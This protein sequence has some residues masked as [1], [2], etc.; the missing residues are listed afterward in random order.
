MYNF[1]TSFC[2]HSRS[3]LFFFLVFKH[4]VVVYYFHFKSITCQNRFSTF[5]LYVPKTYF[6]C[7][8]NRLNEPIVSYC[9]KSKN[10]SLS[11][12]TNPSSVTYRK[13]VRGW[14]FGYDEFR[15]RNPG[16]HEI[17]IFFVYESKSKF[18]V[19]CRGGDWTLLTPLLRIWMYL[20]MFYVILKLDV[21]VLVR[22]SGK[23]EI[24]NFV[25]HSL[26]VYGKIRQKFERFD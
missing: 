9:G 2:I 18:F 26:N 21:F 22:W 7:N 6:S 14:E 12:F 17:T 3:P 10:K 24:Q 25:G 8:H 4:S 16:R 15:K 5:L 11:L 19:D 1:N 20:K 13:V 23:I